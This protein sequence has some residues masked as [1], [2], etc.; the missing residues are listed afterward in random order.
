MATN[1]FYKC[2]HPY[3]QQSFQLEQLPRISGVKINQKSKTFRPHYVLPKKALRHWLGHSGRHWNHLVLRL[4]T[5]KHL[6]YVHPNE[7][8]V[9]VWQRKKD[10]V[11]FN[12]RE[13]L[14]SYVGCCIS[15]KNWKIS[16]NAG[17]RTCV[18]S[19]RRLSSTPKSPPF[20]FSRECFTN[21]LATHLF[22]V[23]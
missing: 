16:V 4:L 3:Q 20:P 18:L 10:N 23:F 17:N 21:L 7:P 11:I 5:K 6:W 15:V 8:V 22:A 13:Q 19:I 14:S 2:V 12:A 9:A 1:N